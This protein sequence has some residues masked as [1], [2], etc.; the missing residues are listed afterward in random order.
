[1]KIL[2]AEDSLTSRMLL[3]RTLDCQELTGDRLR[4]QVRDAGH[5]IAPQDVKKLFTPF[6]RLGA[7]RRAIDGTGIGLAL[8]KLPLAHNSL[9]S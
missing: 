8:S 3:T 1:M 5:A 9:H 7:E 6:E 4:I 2:I